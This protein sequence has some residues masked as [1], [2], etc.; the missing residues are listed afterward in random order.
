MG[1]ELVVVFASGF[2]LSSCFCF[3]GKKVLSKNVG[4]GRMESERV[5]SG[6]L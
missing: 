2:V 3:T 6:L 4:G 5:G 1:R